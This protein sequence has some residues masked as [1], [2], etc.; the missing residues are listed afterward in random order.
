MDVRAGR[1]DGA[2]RTRDQVRRPRPQVAAAQPCRR[3]TQVDTTHRPRH[4]HAAPTVT[5]GW[6]G[7]P[8]LSTLPGGP[9]QTPAAA[10]TDGWPGRPLGLRSSP[11]PQPPPRALQWWYQLGSSRNGGRDVRDAPAI[12]LVSSGDRARASQAAHLSCPGSRTSRCARRLCPQAQTGC[13]SH[14]GGGLLAEGVAS[15]RSRSP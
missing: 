7:R 12:W 11:R 8:V 1:C 15:P 2:L 10:G 13:L 14:L 4:R 6:G 3:D 5:G 9:D